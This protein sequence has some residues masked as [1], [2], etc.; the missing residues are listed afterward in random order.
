MVCKVI[1]S[2][3]L[4]PYYGGKVVSCASETISGVLFTALS[5]LTVGKVKKYN[6]DAQN[7]KNSVYILPY[8]YKGMIGLLGGKISK[9][10][11][12]E[13]GYFRE[14]FD[15]PGS[16]LSS[17]NGSLL[18]RAQIQ[19][20]TRILYALMA[21]AAVVS[22]IAD[23]ILG[24]V[25]ALLSVISFGRIKELNQFALAN[26]TVF[27]MIDDVTRGIRGFVNPYQTDLD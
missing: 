2:A 24:S 13:R 20:G 5:V 11:K 26:L 25:A 16:G 14:K 4:L 21:V 3:F 15:F 19:V 9:T 23:L 7:T 17:P 27:G 6:G 12:P 1:D 8:A 22:R 10:D 18:K